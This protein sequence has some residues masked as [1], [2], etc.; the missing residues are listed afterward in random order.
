MPEAERHWPCESCGADLRF[1]PGQ[2]ELICSYCGHRQ[3]IPAASAESAANL[4]EIDLGEGLRAD[5]ANGRNQ[6]G[7][8]GLVEEIRTTRCPNCGALVEF[9]AAGHATECPF[10]ATPVVI[11][12]GAQRQ[13]KPQGVVPFRLSEGQARDAMNHWMG[14][15]WFAPNNLLEFSR[16]GRA[17][18]GVYVPYW[19]F[20]AST[21]SRYSGARGDYYYETRTVTVEVDGRRQQRQEQVRHI[22][23]RPVS[24]RV[25]RFFD[26]VLVMA[27]HSLPRGHTEAL[28]PWDFTDLKPYSADYL[29]GFAAE[30][31]T[32][33]LADGRQISQQEMQRV[34]ANDVR[35]AI[36]GDEQRINAIDTDYADETFKHILLPIWMA[37]YKYGGKTYRFVVNGQSGKVKGERPYSIWKI[38]FAIILALIACGL[39]AYFAEASGALRSS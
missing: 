37:A 10:C 5:S 20:D 36:G 23:W 13:I 4:R 17:M 24:G 3:Q 2:S 38:S 33:S 34:I 18:N 11:G 30:G 35:R 22:R 16:A 32:L 15:L 9:R 26:D 7:E 21:R 8:S 39:F 29:A 12:T 14:S 27:T 31:Y 25:G 1:A 28:A 19:T 6:A